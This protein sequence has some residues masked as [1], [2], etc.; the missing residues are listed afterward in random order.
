MSPVHDSRM[1]GRPIDKATPTVFL[2]AEKAE[3]IDD[4]HHLAHDTPAGNQPIAQGMC[5]IY[6]EGRA[7]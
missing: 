7:G 5:R 3:G 2:G 4:F 6:K 1:L